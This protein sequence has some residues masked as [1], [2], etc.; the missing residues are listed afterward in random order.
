MQITKRLLPL[1]L[2]TIF[3]SSSVYGQDPGQVTR[4][5]RQLRE[6]DDII[7]RDFVQSKENIEVKEKAT[8][9]E[10]SGDIRFEF[11]N[12][13]E[14]GD[15]LFVKF[16]DGFDKDG[17]SIPVDKRFTEQYRSYRGGNAIDFAHLPICHNDWDVEFNL[18]VKYTYDRAWGMAQVQ[19]DNSAGVRG[20]ECS[21]TIDITGIEKF[22][23]FSDSFSSSSSSDDKFFVVRRDSRRTLKGSGEAG[24]TSLKRAFMGYNIV[25]DGKHRLD[26]E[27]GRRKLDDLFVSEIEFSSRFDGIVFK[28]ASEIEHNPWYTNIGAFVIDERVN[29]YGFVGEIG[30]LNIAKSGLDLRYSIID[31][32]K[33][34]KNRCFLRNPEGYDFLNSQISFSYNFKLDFFCKKQLPAEIYGGFLINHDAKKTI[35]TR[36]KKKNLG[37]YLGFYLGEVEKKGDWALDIE[38][39]VIQAQAVPDS[40]VGG[41][42][43]GNIWDEQIYDVIIGTDIEGVVGESLESVVVIDNTTKKASLVTSSELT[44]GPLSS[45]SVTV[46]NAIIP[47]RGNANFI[48]G[49]I[50]YLYAITDNFSVDIEAE[51]SWAE[52]NRIGGK[53]TYANYEIECIYAF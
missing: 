2:A 12:L 43:R 1:L 32:N 25:A 27:I 9:L 37:W 3:L 50:E 8:E 30:F 10:I 31:W 29:H 48:G 41:I 16:R 44:T 26:I 51:L 7:V 15:K 19:F 53:H 6:R 52:D 4:F 49:R 33:P 24:N 5:D 38:Y 42:A 46:L 47:R 13:H 45:N 39:M 17:K 23:D 18:K 21:R 28:Y 14:K 36:Y 11:R 40:D 20:R 35:F 34:G 22:D